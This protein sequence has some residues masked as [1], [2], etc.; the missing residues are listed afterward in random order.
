ML[1]RVPCGLGPGGFWGRLCAVAPAGGRTAA[2]V[3]LVAVLAAV[4][5]L[6]RPGVPAGLVWDEGYYATSTQRYLD[7]RAQFGTHPP[8]G[9]MLLAAGEAA[10]RP[11]ASIDT[12]RVGDTKHIA[13][14]ALPAGYSPVG[15]RLASGS[16]AAM[17]A[18]VLLML[19][20][21]LA[22][23]LPAALLVANLY[24]FDNAL[25]AHLRAAHLDAFQLLFSLLALWAWASAVR[26]A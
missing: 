12:S 26:R 6:V 4:V 11:N 22:G 13:G 15:M 1:G 25:V 3:V 20:L 14:E 9:L 5:F 10:L 7:G 23:S 8:L 24:L 16:A 19:V 17:G 18:V 2:A 21:R